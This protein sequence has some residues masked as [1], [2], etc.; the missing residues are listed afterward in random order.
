MGVYHTTYNRAFFKELDQELNTDIL[1]FSIDG[2]AYFGHLQRIENCHTAIL[3]PAIAACTSDVE[4]I[5][6]G[7]CVVTVDFVRVDLCSIIAKGTGIVRDPVFCNQ[8]PESNCCCNQQQNCCCN[9][10]EESA[11]AL[12]DA[13]RLE[14]DDDC[15]VRQLRRLIGNDVSLTTLGGFLFQGILSDVC[16]DLALLSIDEIYIPGGGGYLSD[17]NI[18]S[19]T[20][21]VKAVNSVA[22]SRRDCC[23]Q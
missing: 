15:T 14:R 2:F 6:P 12:P 3:A 11:E 13:D 5:T 18:R 9:R 22:E 10:D 1:L 17:H 7:G 19:V 21:N 16:H 4:I 23:C 20:V 8:E